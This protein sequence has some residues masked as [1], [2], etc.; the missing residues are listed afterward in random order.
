MGSRVVG[1]LLVYPVLT[2]YVGSMLLLA[3]LCAFTVVEQI[4]YVQLQLT[5]FS[6]FWKYYLLK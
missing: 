2:A 5:V 1:L 6:R 3:T 4:N